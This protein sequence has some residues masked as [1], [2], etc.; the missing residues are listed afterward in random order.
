MKFGLKKDTIDLICSVFEK[1]PPLEKVIVYG[2]RAK[3]NYR[4]GSDIDLSC[5]GNDL[6]L[7]ILHQIENDIDDLLLPYSFDI[8]IFSHVSNESLKEHIE[9]VGQVFYD[10]KRN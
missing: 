8:S 6:T 5:F 7:T 4:N 9:R 10:T 3:G 1:H 2:S